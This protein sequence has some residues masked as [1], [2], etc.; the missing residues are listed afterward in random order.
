MVTFHDIWWYL[1]TFH[2]I[3]WY[4]VIFHEKTWR[5]SWYIMKCHD[6]SWNDSIW[7]RDVR[8]RCEWK[9]GLSIV[10]CYCGEWKSGPCLLGYN[11]MCDLTP[12]IFIRSILVFRELKKGSLGPRTSVIKCSGV[13]SNIFLYRR[14]SLLLYLLEEIDSLLS[15][16]RQF[17][18]LMNSTLRPRRNIHVSGKFFKIIYVDRFEK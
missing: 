6:K 3:W 8:D 11:K 18:W 17:G 5:F 14:S 10:I 2:D 16:A 4:L 1:V 15:E 12:L 13:K 7:F 9:S